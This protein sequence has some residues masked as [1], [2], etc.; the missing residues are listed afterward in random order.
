MYSAFARE[1]FDKSDYGTSPHKQCFQL[2]QN[3]FYQHSDN[4][5]CNVLL[6]T[7]SLHRKN[8]LVY[9]HSDNITCNVLLV[10]GSLHRKNV[11]QHS[12]N[13]R[14]NVLSLQGHFQALCSSHISEFSKC[15]VNS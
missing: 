8:V 3:F 12:D 4:I 14:V 15:K 6:V 13:I 7:G 11:Y 9:Q 1:T 2:H 10:T 5:T